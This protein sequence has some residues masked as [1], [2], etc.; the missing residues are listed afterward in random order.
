MIMKTKLLRW[1][2]AGF[3]VTAL[4]GTLLHF[5]YNLTKQSVLI[6]TFSSVN[7]S[8]WEHMKLLFFPMFIFALIQ[9]RFFKEYKNFWC[10]KLVGILT[11]LVLIPILFYTYNGVI[12]KSPDWFNI[13]IFFISAA[14]TFILEIWLF[15]RDTLHCKLPWLAFALICLIGVMFVVFTFVTPQIPLFQDPLTG[16]YGISS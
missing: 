9:S 15:K 14:A 10:V 8:T 2:F 6:A 12:G 11:G 1:Q 3:I 4:G 7:E 16:T 5:L 13:T